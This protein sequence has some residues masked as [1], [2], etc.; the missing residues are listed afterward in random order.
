ML[1]TGSTLAG[2]I[3]IEAPGRCSASTVEGGRERPGCERV[4]EGPRQRLAGRYLLAL[5][6]PAGR[7]SCERRSHLYP[8]AVG[9]ANRLDALRGSRK[10]RYSIRINRQWRICFT[11]SGDQGPADVVAVDYH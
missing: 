1:L 3:S 7:H 11:W 2:A 10:G 5:P 8:I 4:E 9:A 6:T